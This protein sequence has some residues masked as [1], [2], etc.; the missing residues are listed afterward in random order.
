MSLEITKCEIPDVLE[1]Q[2]DI[3]R[4]ERGYFTEFFNK[5]VLEEAGFDW[6]DRAIRPMAITKDEKF[7]YLQISLFHGF[8][9]YDM[10]NDKITRKLELPIPEA[11]KNLAPEDHILN[12]GHHGIALSGDDKTICVAGTM[13]GYIAIVDRETFEYHTIKLSDD[14]KAAKPYWATSSRDGTKAYVSISG[15]DKVS[16]VDYATG[17]IVAEVPVGNHP[18]RVRNGQLRLK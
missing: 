15:L 18:Q 9:E 5:T 6:I 17:K 4:D 3:F 7:A 14:P 1:I 16:V 12:S 8:F 10:V 13:D 11:N 2:S